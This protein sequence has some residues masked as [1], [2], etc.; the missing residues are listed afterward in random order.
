MTT[1]NITVPIEN[2]ELLSG[3]LSASE[4][5]LMHVVYLEE[6][7]K[8]AAKFYFNIQLDVNQWLQI[9]SHKCI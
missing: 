4:D 8:K 1:S 9:G 3:T 7:H 5:S 6:G 2:E